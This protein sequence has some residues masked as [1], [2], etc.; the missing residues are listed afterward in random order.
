MQFIV[1]L[2]IKTAFAVNGIILTIIHWKISIN[3]FVN[4]QKNYSVDIN[5]DI[6]HHNDLDNLNLYDKN[7]R[8]F[9]F[10]F[11]INVLQIEKIT[12]PLSF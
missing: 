1:I 2:Q 6:F 4:S 5:I 9:D 10:S 12:D 11:K 3:L 7:I 8:L